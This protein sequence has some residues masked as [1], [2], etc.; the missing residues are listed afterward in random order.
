MLDYDILN[1]D[2]DGRIIQLA[3]YT[4]NLFER[5]IKGDKFYTYKLVNGMYLIYVWLWL[6][7]ICA[8]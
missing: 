7:N 1:S 3:K 8:N 5:I 4:T 6:Y 2:N